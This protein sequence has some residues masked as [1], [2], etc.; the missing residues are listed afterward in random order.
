MKHLW[1]FSFGLLSAAF[2]VLAIPY[3]VR[4]PQTYQHVVKGVHAQGLL[5]ARELNDAMD[6]EHRHILEGIIADVLRKPTARERIRVLQGMGRLSFEYP[7]YEHVVDVFKDMNLYLF[8]I[9]KTTVNVFDQ[10]LPSVNILHNYF[11]LLENLAIGANKKLFRR[12]RGI[13]RTSLIGVA[14]ELYGEA[15]YYRRRGHTYEAHNRILIAQGLLY[16]I[17]DTNSEAKKLYKELDTHQPV[18]FVKE[19]QKMG[20]MALCSEGDTNPSLLKLTYI[21]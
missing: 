20:V 14:K 10:L 6:M 7:K 4:Q 17:K 21:Y 8:Y 3:I 12:L 1:F 5:T 18:P 11:Y 9:L 19:L 16:R 13:F 15:E 2:G